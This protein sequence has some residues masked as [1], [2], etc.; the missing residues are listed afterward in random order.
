MAPVLQLLLMQNLKWQ[1]NSYPE[2]EIRNIDEILRV[3]TDKGVKR[4][5]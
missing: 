5:I 1:K 3:S 4:I 2:A